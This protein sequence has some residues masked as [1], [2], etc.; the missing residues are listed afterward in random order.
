MDALTQ[1]ITPDQ[2]RGLILELTEDALVAAERFQRR[3]LP[4]LRARGLR[5]SIDD[6]GTGYSSLAMLSDE[7][8]DEVKIDRTFI[9]QVH[10]R[11]RSQG[12][13]RAIES[14]CGALGIAVVAEGVE[15]AEELDYLRRHTGIRC[16]QGYW[17]ARPPALDELLTGPDPVRLPP[18][19]A[20]T[21]EKG[22]VMPRQVAGGSPGS[23]AWWG[24]CRGDVPHLCDTPPCPCCPRR[25]RPA[26]AARPAPAP[27]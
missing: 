22:D 25:P 3:V 18:P 26:P 10:Q 19:R 9:S 12:I 13:L 11:P 6:F 23:T 24:R 1:D 5:V 14:L 2:A 16:A 8:A 27:C 4:L 21:R 20:Q 15:T 17:F 7:I